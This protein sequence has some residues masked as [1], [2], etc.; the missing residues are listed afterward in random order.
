MKTKKLRVCIKPEC[1]SYVI[2]IENRKQRRSR[3]SD[4]KFLFHLRFP[5]QHLL[6]SKKPDKFLPFYIFFA[7]RRTI[8]FFSFTTVGPFYP[9]H[10]FIISRSHY[11][12]SPVC[13]FPTSVSFI[14]YVFDHVF[15]SLCC[16]ADYCPLF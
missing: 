1:L 2:F 6:A 8:S 12:R 15:I 10:F 9:G 4:W 3:K 5:Q 13:F 16:L 11:L 7:F 14:P